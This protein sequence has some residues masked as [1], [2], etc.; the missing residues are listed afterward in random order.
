M[1]NIIKLYEARYPGRIIGKKVRTVEEGK[2]IGVC[3][4]V[5]VDIDTKEVSVLVSCGEHILRVNIHKIVGVEDDFIVVDMSL[6]VEYPSE[7][8]IEVELTD[9]R[10]EIRLIGE[11]MIRMT[12]SKEHKNKQ[13][14]G[15][16]DFARILFA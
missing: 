4:G 9:L 2:I 13:S 14:I 3:S 10:E 16:F 7:K 12:T 1:R 8:S 15:N 6:P 5:M 11:L